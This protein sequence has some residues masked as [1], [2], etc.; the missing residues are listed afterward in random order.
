VRLFI[1][2]DIHGY[3]DLWMKA[4]K[5]AGFDINNDNHAIAVLGD[6]L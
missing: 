4:L 6:L 3:Y 2:S 5:E 1:S